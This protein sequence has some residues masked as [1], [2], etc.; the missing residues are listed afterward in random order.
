LDYTATIK[1]WDPRKL[2]T[3]L[4]AT[5]CEYC[6]SG[7]LIFHGLHNFV[8]DRGKFPSSDLRT[9]LFFKSVAML[10]SNERMF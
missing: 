9:S 5:A 3:T 2:N 4:A 6:R 1:Q 8:F 7:S 10:G